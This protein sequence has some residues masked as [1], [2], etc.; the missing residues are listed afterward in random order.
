MSAHRSMI[1][2]RIRER[3]I[4]SGIKQSDLARRAGI[5]PS[6]LNLIEH[7]KRRIGGKTLMQ[8]AEALGIEP[9][10]LSEGAEAALVATLREAAGAI[11]DSLAE[12]DHTED[13]AGRFPG[14]A[15]LLITLSNRCVALEQTVETL[16]DR[17]AH[18][19]QLATSLHEVISAVTAI[20]STASIL[21][22]TQELEP[23]W[24]HRF[25]RNMNEDSARLVDSAETLVRYLEAAPDINAEIKAPQD[26]LHAF[27]SDNGFHFPDLEIQDKEPDIEG[28]IDRA[29]ALTTW[30]SKVLAREFLVQYLDDARRMPLPALMNAIKAAGLEPDQLAQ[31]FGVE[32]TAVFRRLALLPADLVGPLGLVICD[33]TGTV[34]FRKS[35]LGFHTPRSAGACAL[36]PLYQVLANPGV[37]LRQRL[38]Q[39]GREQTSVL[40]LA[41]ADIRTVAFDA[42]PLIRPHMLI[43][44]DD[45][46]AAASQARDVGV[47][48]RICPIPDCRA[49]RE[50]SILAVGF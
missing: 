31:E 37:A 24:Q 21:A 15:Q 22:E 45:L 5:S 16:T 30:S 23:E 28:I 29:S 43:L 39:L 36:W 18:D 4:Q 49:R 19:P 13:F 1:G 38:R 42:A 7:N 12:V 26:E 44:P 46:S 9:A 47:S 10:L 50:P 33:G 34:T 27:L 14:W 20:H 17:L 3:R 35:S 32:I 25:H 48:C 11:K 41:A 6:Y 2:A 8:L 40:A